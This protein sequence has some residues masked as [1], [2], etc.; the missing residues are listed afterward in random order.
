MSKQLLHLFNSDDGMLY[1][2]INDLNLVILLLDLKGKKPTMEMILNNLQNIKYFASKIV[3]FKIDFITN[4]I[5]KICNIKNIKSIIH[6]LEILSDKLSKIL[7]K[8]VKKLL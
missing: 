3:K 4:D 6:S 8:D 1:K 2:V 7:N 5:D